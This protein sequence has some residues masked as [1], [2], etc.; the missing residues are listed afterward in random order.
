MSQRLTKRLLE[1]VTPPRKGRLYLFDT[2]LPGF[3]AVITETG[4]ITFVARYR[5]LGAGRSGFSKRL[6]LGRYPTI[7]VDSARAAART[8]LAN[9]AH[10]KDPALERADA[11]DAMRMRELGTAWLEDGEARWKDRTHA[12]W[13]RLWTKSLEPAIGNRIVTSITTKDVATIH[14]KHRAKR[15]V[16]NRL[17]DALVS[18][19]SYAE[20]Q[21]ITPKRSNP[22]IDVKRFKERQVERFLTPEET[23]RLADALT[24]AA[25]IGIPPAPTKRKAYK[26]GATSKHTTKAKLAGIYP[27][28]NP[29]A[30]AAIRFLL[31]TGWRKNEALKLTW[32]D[33]DQAR[34]VAVLPNTKTGK[35]ARHLGAHAIALLA[36]LPRAKGSLYVFPGKDPKRPILEINRVW[37]AVRHAAELD[38]VRL[39]DLRHSFASTLASSGASLLLIGKLL[40]HKSV[41]STERYSHLLDD[42]VRETANAATATI[43]ALLAPKL[44]LVKEG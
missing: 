24:A 4:T 36:S 12:E 32:R 28:A 10:G 22:A 33:V 41:R 9:V 25:T 35:S 38:D 17:R 11:K 20:S 6:T 23:V 44:V 7:T 5:V 31:L 3:G 8:A 16:A 26:T 21:G 29:V 37:F 42:P 13:K 19:F 15:T 27:R 2:E 40:G 39:H 1:T 14:H 18:L 43:A 34:G 30:I